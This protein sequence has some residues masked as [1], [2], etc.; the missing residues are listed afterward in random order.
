MKRMRCAAAVLTVCLFSGCG[1]R[2]DEG[3][4]R[5]IY[6]LQQQIAELQQQIASQQEASPSGSAGAGGNGQTADQAGGTGGNGGGQEQDAAPPQSSPAQEGYTLSDLSDM[7]DAYVTKAESA[8]AGSA[9]DL[10]EF[11]ELRQEAMEL[12]RE[13]DWYEDD[14]EKLYRDGGLPADE[15]KKLERELDLLEDKLDDAE[16]RLEYIFG[17]DD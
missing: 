3:A 17:I 16:D 10:E 14:M 15:Y 11:F 5:Q 7:V 8:E 2:T 6:E 12:E 4:Q 13:L 1:S 9:A